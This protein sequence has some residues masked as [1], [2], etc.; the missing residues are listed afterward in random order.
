M[1]ENTNNSK[2]IVSFED[3]KTSSQYLKIVINLLGYEL[4]NFDNAPEGIEYLKNNSADLVLM[5]AQLPGMN[6]YQATKIIKSEIPGLPVIMQSAYAMKSDVDKAIQAGCDDYLSKPIS[7]SNL[8][9]KIEKFIEY[10]VEQ[11]K[12]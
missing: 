9:Q 2:K 4:T 8:K 1:K 10:R 7:M 12:N 3:D 11:I 6:G 5:D